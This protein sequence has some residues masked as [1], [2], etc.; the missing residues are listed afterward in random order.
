M[1]DDFDDIYGSKFLGAADLNGQRKRVKIV[2]T[3]VNDLREK[4]GST[5]RKYIVWFETEEKALVLNK[6]NALRLAQ[7]YG[8]HR[9]GWNGAVIELY[10]EMTTLGKEGI[11]LRPLRSPPQQQK[12][13]APTPPDEDSS[14]PFDDDPNFVRDIV[15]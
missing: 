14:P 1:S 3:E 15:A 2:D 10:G 12:P 8:K 11:R 4:D 6:T 5:K 7:A 9:E 13:Q